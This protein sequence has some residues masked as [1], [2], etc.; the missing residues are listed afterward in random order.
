MHFETPSASRVGRSPWEG[1]GLA[2]S[3]FCGLQ[4]GGGWPAAGTSGVSSRL[5][6]LEASQNGGRAGTGPGLSS[7]LFKA[8]CS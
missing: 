7:L 3:G 2:D 6:W 5:S 8:G 1:E 4:E